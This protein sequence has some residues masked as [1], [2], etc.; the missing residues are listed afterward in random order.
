MRRLAVIIPGTIIVLSVAWSAFWFYAANDIAARVASW[1]AAQR[2]QG[3]VAEYADLSVSGFPLSWRTH[4]AA[5]VMTGAGPTRWEWRGEAVTAEIRPWALHDVPVTFPGVHRISGGAGNVAETFAIRAE[6][7]HG[8][9]V[10]TA[11]GRLG[12]L[13]LDLGD[14]QIQR[15]PN[16]AASSARRLRLSLSP[17]RI[18]QPTYRTDTLDLVLQIEDLSVPEMRR[19]ALGNQIAAAEIDAS[20]KGALP[21]APLAEAV[22]SWR[23]SGGVIELNRIALRWGPLEANGEGTLALDDANRPLG[24]MTARSRGYTETVDALAAAGAVRPR[25]AGMLK[26][27]LNLVARQSG[28]GG[29]RELNVPITAQDGRLTVAGFSLLALQP[30]TFE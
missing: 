24:A 10:L 11:D 4:V 9:I 3:L 29:P 14:A 21:P 1:A 2:A 28:S 12:N 18:A 5:P 22:A 26:I 16:P 6:R 25:D 23:D 15:L 27:A 17:H 13:L 20:F 19:Y 30:L 7:P 8:R